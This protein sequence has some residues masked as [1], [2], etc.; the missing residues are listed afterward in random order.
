MID[1]ALSAF[2]AFFV[3]IDP[4]GLGPMFAGLS[5]GMT[6]DARRRTAI[7]GVAIAAL[8]LFSFALVG[9]LLLAS[10]GIGTGAF[11]LA[12]G[13]LLLLV[14]VDMV[15]ARE[16]GLTTA[17]EDER[18]EARHRADISVFPLAIPL[19]AG[20]GAMT[21]V[22]LLIGRTQNDWLA[23]MV[24]LMTLAL[25]LAAT[26]VVLLFAGEISRF[27]GRTG[28]N[29]INRVLGILLTALACQFILDGIVESGVFAR[30]A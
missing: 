22:A 25:T 11:R 7:K 24:V 4:I 9:P 10:L 8:I 27:M 23:L 20:P 12:G 16:S 17:T 3:T 26:L 5:A 21:S 29:V 13:I 6:A 14:A 19:I 1:L 30:A 18:Q 15:F 28:I 2:I